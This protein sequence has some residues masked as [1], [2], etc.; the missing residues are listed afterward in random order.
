MKYSLELK[1]E[2]I[3]KYKNYR[4][5]FNSKEELLAAMEEYIDYYNNKRIYS[6]R[7]GLSPLMYRQQSL[8]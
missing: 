2:C 1:I 4:Y 7:K 8:K 3:K 6:K 5:V